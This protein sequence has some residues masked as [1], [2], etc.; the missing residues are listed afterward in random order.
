VKPKQ[1]VPRVLAN[2]DVEAAFVHYMEKAGPDAAEGFMDALASGYSHI[3]RFPGTG[4]P[5]YAVTLNLGGLR[6]WALGRYPY[7]VFYIEMP[8]HI[9]VI[10][11]VH[12]AMDLARLLDVK[13]SSA[14][15]IQESVPE[16]G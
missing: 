5:R 9:D 16:W 1:I 10:R 4:S 15:L 12:G 8:D 14:G 13:G 3:A 11:V 6:F 7:L 2:R